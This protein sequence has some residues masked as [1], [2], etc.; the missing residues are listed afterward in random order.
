MVDV[1]VISADTRGEEILFLP[2]GVLL[3][4]GYTRV[5]DQLHH[6]AAFVSQP[7]LMTAI[8]TEACDT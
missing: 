1:E 4:R 6:D 2:V 5:P 7:T 3:P 8:M